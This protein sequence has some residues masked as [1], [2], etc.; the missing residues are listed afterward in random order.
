MLNKLKTLKK[1]N[2]ALYEQL[3]CLQCD[4]KPV[5]AS[6]FRIGLITRNKLDV[7]S[8][9]ADAEVGFIQKFWPKKSYVLSIN[10]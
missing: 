10:G 9:C 5:Q 1:Q 4:S 8:A 7:S 3:E 6:K 2:I